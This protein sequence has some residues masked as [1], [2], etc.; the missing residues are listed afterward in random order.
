V[1]SVDGDGV[2]SAASAAVS[3]SAGDRSLG[4]SSAG[5]G[6][7]GGCFITTIEK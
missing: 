3:V 5:G 2:E 4:G 6:G 1:K 7:G